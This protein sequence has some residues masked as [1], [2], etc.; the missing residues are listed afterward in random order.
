MQEMCWINFNMGCIE[1]LRNVK[2]GVD[3]QTIN[4]NMGCIEILCN[5][6]YVPIQ[7]DKL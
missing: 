7:A 5:N 6:C 2:I 3:P 1:M 4:F